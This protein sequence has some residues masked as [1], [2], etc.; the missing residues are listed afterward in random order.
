VLLP[1]FHRIRLSLLGSHNLGMSKKKIN[2]SESCR[3]LRFLG[4]DKVRL[5][6]SLVVAL[7]VGVSLFG[8]SSISISLISSCHFGIKKIKY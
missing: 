3:S 7:L 5:G 6:F 1:T 2:L 4:L 8:S